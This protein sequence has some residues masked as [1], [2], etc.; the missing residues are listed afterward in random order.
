LENLQKCLQ[1]GFQHVIIVCP[2]VSRL[3]SLKRVIESQLPADAIG[4]VRFFVPDDLFAFIQE[5]EANELQQEQTVRGY[6][7]RTDYRVLPSDG[8]GDRREAVSRVIA[9]ALLRTRKGASRGKARQGRDQEA[10]GHLD[11]GLH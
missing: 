10:G 2:K 3:E 1:A 9:E 7:V 11:Q 4:R 8:R 5:L 6:R